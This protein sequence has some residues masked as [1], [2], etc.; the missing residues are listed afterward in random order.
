MPIQKGKYLVFSTE[1]G[2]NEVE[3][4][5]NTS[6]MQLQGRSSSSEA[7]NPLLGMY[8]LKN[9]YMDA[10]ELKKCLEEIKMPLAPNTGYQRY[11]FM[12]F[13][14]KIHHL[15]K[16][17]PEGF[18]MP[19]GVW[20][21]EVPGNPERAKKLGPHKRLANTDSFYTDGYLNLLTQN[22]WVQ[23]KLRE[24]YQDRGVATSLVFRVAQPN[25]HRHLDTEPDFLYSVALVV[26]GMNIEDRRHLREFELDLPYRGNMGHKPGL[27]EDLS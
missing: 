5:V 6:F 4:L 19:R 1:P 21:N 11:A 9:F 10:E 23:G 15:K 25:P 27:K 13:P 7:R 22:S 8:D 26:R 20:R 2:E 3:D 24:A 14:T 18:L 12:L 17:H 16:Q